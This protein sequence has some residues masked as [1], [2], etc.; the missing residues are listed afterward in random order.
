MSLPA[1]PVESPEA[2]IARLER[3]LERERDARKE[4][5]R[6]L[7]DKSRELY[8]A[9]RSL[10]AF[11][12][13]LEG[14][15]DE[16]TVAL[17]EALG[18]AEA[19]TRAKSEFLATMSHEIRTPLNGVVGMVELLQSTALDDTQRGYVDTLLQSADTL[20]A[21]INDVLDFS[22]IEAGRLELE[23][24]AFSPL[25]LAQDVVALIAPQATQKGLPVRLHTG[26]LPGRVLGDPTRLQQV[27]LNLLSN[28]VKFT[29]RGVV[30]LELAAEPSADGRWRLHGAVTDTG[31]GMTEAQ[32]ARL[33]E[34]FTQVDASMARRYGGSGLGLAISS[35]L[36]GLMDGRIDVRS[37]PG[38]GSRFGFELRLDPVSDAQPIGP[39]APV[40][41]SPAPVRRL[42]VLLAED[43]PINQ[44]VALATLSRLGIEAR[45]VRNGAEAVEAVRAERYDVVLMDMQMPGVDG[46]EATRRIRE[47]GGTVGQPWIVAVTANAF[48]HDR[49]RC[50]AAG[51]DD[52][53]AKPF[54]SETLRRALDRAARREGES[55]RR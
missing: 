29:E 45:L 32:C 33:F 37:R 35:R 53:V 34:A 50:L 52:F 19:G 11:A 7:E 22:R 26:T 46:V 6:L 5:E 31:I 39:P 24:R 23:R 41:L 10:Q 18:R 30:T 9:N 44:Q 43:N 49:E 55:E 27:W 14:L 13:R 51:M 16:R 42:K 36:I 25:R 47:A 4:A 12:D 8:D 38:E 48:E 28:A 20:L 17:R 3:R 54:R 21:I 15:V 40:A 1:G 2:R